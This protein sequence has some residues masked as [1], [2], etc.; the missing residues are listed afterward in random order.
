VEPGENHE[1]RFWTALAESNLLILPGSVFNGEEN[2][3]PV[4]PNIT[5]HYRISFSNASVRSLP[6]PLDH[7]LTFLQKEQMKTGV[8]IL[9]KV[10]E[11]YF[12]Q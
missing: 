10:L 3:P 9:A 6:H 12:K 2:H 5:G 11:E 8:D 7:F 1:T 4:D